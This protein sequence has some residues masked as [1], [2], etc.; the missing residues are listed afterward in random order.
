MKNSE[1]D[2]DNIELIISYYKDDIDHEL[3]N[4]C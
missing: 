3:V 1:I 2:E 4:K